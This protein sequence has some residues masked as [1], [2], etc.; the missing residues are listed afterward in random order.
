MN[1]EKSVEYSIAPVD[2]LRRI[3]G[4]ERLHGRRYKWI[5]TVSIVDGQRVK[6]RMLVPAGELIYFTATG[7]TEIRKEKVQ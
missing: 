3:K 4:N 5:D 7:G 2:R 6:G 1:R